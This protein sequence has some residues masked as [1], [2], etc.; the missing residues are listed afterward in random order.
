EAAGLLDAWVTPDGRLLGKVLV[1]ERVSNVAFGGPDR[2][3][4]FMT[5]TTSLYS[6]FLAVRGCV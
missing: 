6:I 1:P 5:A 3:R 2:N 4:L